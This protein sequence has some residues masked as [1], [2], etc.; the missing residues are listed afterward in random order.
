MQ[1]RDSTTQRASAHSMASSAALPIVPSTHVSRLSRPT[2]LSALTCP[3]PWSF[4]QPTPLERVRNTRSRC[5][6][7][8][9][10]MTPLTST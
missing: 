3:R 7:S 8:W 10:T 2:P 6:A 1:R 9:V 4:L 5:C